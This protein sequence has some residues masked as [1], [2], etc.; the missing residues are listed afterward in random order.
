MLSEK[1]FWTKQKTINP[2]P[3]APPNSPLQVKWSVPNN[4]ILSFQYL[5]KDATIVVSIVYILCRIIRG[6]NLNVRYLQ[7]ACFNYCFQV[8]K[9]FWIYAIYSLF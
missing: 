1:K 4:H 9:Y 5:L 8:E 6:L 3:P 7:E 2:L